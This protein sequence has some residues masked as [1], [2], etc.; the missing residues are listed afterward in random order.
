ME[1]RASE[2]DRDDADEDGGEGDVEG[3]GWRIVVIVDAKTDC[4]GE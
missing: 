3:G 1:E 4:Y 2:K